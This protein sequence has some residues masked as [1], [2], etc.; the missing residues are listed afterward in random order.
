MLACV[1]GQEN[2]TVT[3]SSVPVNG[4]M[5]ALRMVSSQVG[6]DVSS[7]LQAL[8]NPVIVPVLVANRSNGRPDC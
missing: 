5:H 7:K 6:G 1:L 4:G 2:S 3:R 8:S